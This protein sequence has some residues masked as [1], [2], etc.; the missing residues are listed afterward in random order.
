MAVVNVAGRVAVV[1]GGTVL[2]VAVVIGLSLVAV[3]V[4]LRIRGTVPIL[5]ARWRVAAVVVVLDEVLPQPARTVAATSATLIR[6]F[7]RALYSSGQ[8][9]DRHTKRALTRRWW[10][11]TEPQPA[12]CGVFM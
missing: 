3:A 5:L 11:R 8:P 1:V 12:S 4:C 6:N 9:R 7:M 2:V 10:C